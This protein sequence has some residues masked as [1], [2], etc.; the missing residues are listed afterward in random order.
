MRRR[1]TYQSKSIA[2]ITAPVTLLNESATLFRFP[3]HKKNTST[4]TAIAPYAFFGLSVGRTSV[5]KDNEFITVCY[6]NCASPSRD[7]GNVISSY[8]CN[9]VIFMLTF[10]TQF[11]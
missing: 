9:S 5:S 8:G 7:Q 1:M 6:K 2:I 3:V 4:N 11:F 10:K